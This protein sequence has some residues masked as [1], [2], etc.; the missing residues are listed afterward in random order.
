MTGPDPDGL[1]VG[2]RERE[3]AV[4]VLHDAVGGGY[5][6]L[7]EFEERSRTVYAARTR[8]D[9][10][11]A[12]ADLP[13]GAR[14]FPPPPPV[15]MVATGTEPTAGAETM[16]IDWTTRKRRGPWQVPA[17]L[18]I[19]GAMGTADLD[20]REATVPATGCVITVLTSWSTV[21]IR[22]GDTMSVRTQDFEGGSMSALKDKAGAPAGPGGP[23]I[24][25]RGHNDW[26][27]VVLRRA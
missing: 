15:G 14:L 5:L 27:T 6:D 10:R 18:I 24:D 8:G 21:K 7:A 16:E 22:L 4:T 17:H 2:D 26:T 13:A 9:L 19:R 12:L 11:S 20:L 3:Q 1:R 25:I 23:V